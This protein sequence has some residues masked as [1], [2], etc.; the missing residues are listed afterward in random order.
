MKKI[1]KTKEKIKEILKWIKEVREGCK[2][3]IKI[4]LEKVMKEMKKGNYD[5]SSFAGLVQE[6]RDNERDDALL[7]LI[8]EMLEGD[9]I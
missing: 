9:F 2:K 4:D 5:K 6:L 8:E 7:S 1:Q 3:V